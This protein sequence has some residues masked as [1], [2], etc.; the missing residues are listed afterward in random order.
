MRS[1]ISLLAA[2]ALST[3]AL[4][5]AQL[6]VDVQA[7]SPSAPVEVVTA[8]PPSAPLAA[9]PPSA[10]VTAEIARAP[11]EDVSG[12]SGLG[13]WVEQM[14]LT[15]L[16]MS[17]SR[18]EVEALEG[19]RLDAQWEGNIPLQQAVLGGA[20][21]HVGMRAHGYLRGPELRI[22]LGGGDIGGDWAPAP[23]V[24]GLELS[25]QSVFLV[26]LEA[27]MGVQVPLGPVVPYVMGR[28][29]VGGA[30][31]DVAV[32][33]QRLGGLGTE[34]VDAVTLELGVEAGIGF[35]LS[36]GLELGLAFRGSFLG[37]QSLGMLLTLGFDGSTAE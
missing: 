13:M 8:P 18:P 27:A 25:V 29:A 17:L 4:A 30:I 9:E 28:A 33:D 6:E 37:N 32:R 7:P 5:A 35:R 2:L 34:H 1:T 26:R 20:G 31:V 36:P 15:T 23:G 10:P 11:R 16:G 21:L 22:M 19:V 24:E 14:N 3:P 12:Y